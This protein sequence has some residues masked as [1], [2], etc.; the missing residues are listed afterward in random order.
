MGER[1]YCLLVFTTRAGVTSEN[2][3]VPSILHFDTLSASLN[4]LGTSLDFL[5]ASLDLFFVGR[6]TATTDCENMVA[7]RVLIIEAG[8]A[9]I[10]S[11]VCT[12][13]VDRTVFVDW[14]VFVDRLVL[15]LSVVMDGLVLRLP[16]VLVSRATV[17]AV[18]RAATTVTSG[19]LAAGTAGRTRASAWLAGAAATTVASGRL[20]A[21]ARAVALIIALGVALRAL[22]VGLVVRLVRRGRLVVL[23]VG[24]LLGDFN[25]L[26]IRRVLVLVLVDSGYFT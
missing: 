14:T 9:V 18:A 8:T 5:S 12:P 2:W 1:S 13:L 7:Y 17:A 22:L 4:T 23:L 26:S 3:F 6:V 15:V 11:P 20:R 21:G 10:A 19:R 25:T 24:L 16:A